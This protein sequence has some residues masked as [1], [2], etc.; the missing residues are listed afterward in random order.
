[1]ISG[2]RI[3]SRDHGQRAVHGRSGWKRAVHPKDL[4]RG[5]T[6]ARMVQVSP[7]QVG[8]DRGGGG[9]ERLPLHQDAVQVS[10]CGEVSAAYVICFRFI[11]IP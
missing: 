11:T 2:C 8:P 6:L 1:M 3:R 4:S 7:A 10:L 9:L 5:L